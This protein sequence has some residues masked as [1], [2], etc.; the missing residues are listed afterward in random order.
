MLGILRKFGRF[1][2]ISNQCRMFSVM[3]TTQQNSLQK[4]KV[5]KLDEEFDRFLIYLPKPI[6]NHERI[7]EITDDLFDKNGKLNIEDKQSQPKWK[8]EFKSD[9]FRLSSDINISDYDMIQLYKLKYH[10]FCGGHPDFPRIKTNEYRF[11][12]T[13]GYWNS[14]DTSTFKWLIKQKLLY[15]NN[16]ICPYICYQL[17]LLNV[18]LEWT[19]YP[20]M[21]RNHKWM[22]I[23]EEV[24]RGQ[25]TSQHNGPQCNPESDPLFPHHETNKDDTKKYFN[26]FFE[27]WYELMPDTLKQLRLMMAKKHPREYYQNKSINND[28]NEACMFFEND[29]IR[30]KVMTKYY[31]WELKQWI[32]T[33]GTKDI[34]TEI[35]D[36]DKQNDSLKYRLSDTAYDNNIRTIDDEISEPNMD[37]MSDKEFAQFKKEIYHQ[38]LKNNKNRPI[39]TREE[40]GL[41]YLNALRL[42]KIKPEHLNMSELKLVMKHIGFNDVGTYRKNYIR[43]KYQNYK[44][45]QHK[46]MDYACYD[47]SYANDEEGI[48]DLLDVY[49]KTRNPFQP[50]YGVWDIYNPNFQ[51]QTFALKINE[52]LKWWKNTNEG[53]LFYKENPI[54]RDLSNNKPLRTKIKNGIMLLER[55]LNTLN[56]IINDKAYI[57]KFYDE[58]SLNP[59]FERNEWNEIKSKND[60]KRDIQNL[61]NN[62]STR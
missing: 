48:F 51:E 60:I 52:H 28:D 42:G 58:L 54:I 21:D 35:Y 25:E 27:V 50:P 15:R 5:L 1:N 38:H 14:I 56:G 57:L 29:E 3:S 13:D 19:R 32:I 44:D 12:Y 26:P 9:F 18:S 7:Y 62:I 23:Y 55:E 40:L 53:K 36:M 20:L 33:T 22:G 11:H 34:N 59:N 2:S 47:R 39:Y 45:F 30:G 10:I 49:Y 24:V 46:P 4:P 6:K 16:K 43:R 8:T 61:Q 41:Y 17:K 31:D 37:K